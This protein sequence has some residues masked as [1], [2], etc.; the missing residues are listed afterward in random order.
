[1]SVLQVLIEPRQQ[2]PGGKKIFTNAMLKA[3]IVPCSLSS[4][5]IWAS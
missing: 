3:M 5:C 1:M 2:I 4:C